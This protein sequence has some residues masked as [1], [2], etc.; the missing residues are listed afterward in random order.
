M[1]LAVGHLIRRMIPF[2]KAIGQSRD[3]V[4]ASG[5]HRK[6]LERRAKGQGLEAVKIV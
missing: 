3:P 2:S 1:L 4:G 5:L 6:N